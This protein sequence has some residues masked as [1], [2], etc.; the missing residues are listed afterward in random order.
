VRD[1]GG[2]L[3]RP[4]LRAEIERATRA[5]LDATALHERSRA[6]HSISSDGLRQLRLRL[7]AA[8]Q[9]VQ[10]AR[11]QRGEAARGLSPLLTDDAAVRR[12]LVED[13]MALGR[14][15]ARRFAHRGQSL[16]DL[17]Q[18]AMLGLVL[19]AD[20]FDPNVGV[21]FS[22]FATRTILGELKRYF[23]DKVWPVH[24]SRGAKDRYLVIRDELDRLTQELGRS[25]RITDVAERLRLSEEDV[26]ES[27]DAAR[28][29][30]PASL[31]AVP[32]DDEGGDRTLA[33]SLGAP[34]R[35][36]SRVDRR[37][38]VRSL[39]ERLPER[40][41]YIIDQRFTHGRT[42]ADIGS[43]L[44]ISQMHVSRLIARSLS[45]MRAWAEST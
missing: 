2:L 23:R 16:E 4:G 35:N 24:V 11:H 15:L 5:R 8:R 18:V 31:D 41:H 22:T 40:E 27:L 37:D 10:C 28:S 9:Q 42:Q 12:R 20:R 26:V 3:T 25:P 36:F 17:E 1:G 6:A 7:S 34:D 32:D 21:R 13:H 43:Q 30:R 19:A 39:L 14:F 38:L 45:R 44:G 33:T 29:Y